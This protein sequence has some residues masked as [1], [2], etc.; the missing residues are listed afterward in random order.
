[1]R[2]SNHNRKLPQNFY[3]IFWDVIE[4]KSDD[5]ATLLHMIQY[6]GHVINIDMDDIPYL[7]SY[8]DAQAFTYVTSTFHMKQYYAL[9]LKSHNPY[10]QKYME[11]L[12][13]EY[14]N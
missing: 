14:N 4:W 2:R 10:N 6:R 8:W 1:M 5:V 11:A 7:I 9:K 12:S 13:G 3:P